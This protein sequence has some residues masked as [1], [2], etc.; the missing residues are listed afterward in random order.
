M[1]FAALVLSLLAFFSA[2]L[3]RANYQNVDRV[4]LNVRNK[5]RIEIYFIDNI[6][7][8]KLRPISFFVVIVERFLKTQVKFNKTIH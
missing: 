6:H 8:L 4:K 7:C 2:S 5:L 3:Q 1:L